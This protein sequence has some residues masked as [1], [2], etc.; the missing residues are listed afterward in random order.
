MT[1]I[2]ALQSVH[3]AAGA[4]TLAA[5]GIPILSR[6]GGILHRRA[7][8]LYVFAI[9]VA[10]ATSW[11]LCVLRLRDGDRSN[12]ANAIVMAFLGLLTANAVFAGLRVLRLKDRIGPHTHPLD[13]GS[14]ALLALA[15]LATGGYA[16]WH[17]SPVFT[18]LAAVGAFRA[19]DQLRYWLR[20]PG[21]R[22]HWRQEHLA[23]MMTSGIVSL[24]AFLLNVFARN[25]PV[26]WLAPGVVGGAAILLSQRY[27]RRAVATA[28]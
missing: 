21:E 6:K 1:A 11:I 18:A 3:I 19:V 26:L 25:S 5:L 28:E 15:S 22:M 27:Y 24:T 8:W 2:G 16:L 17:G 9:G 10:V 14:S 7:G 23:N 12:D 4:V 13:V 20:P